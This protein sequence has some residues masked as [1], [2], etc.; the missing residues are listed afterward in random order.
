[1]CFSLVARYAGWHSATQQS[2]WD[3][4]TGEPANGQAREVKQEAAD[5]AE[6]KQE[7]PE[8]AEVKQEAAD[9]AE[10]KQEAPESE[11]EAAAEMALDA[12][13]VKEEPQAEAE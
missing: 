11:E 10:V 2:Q 4:P 1:M 5:S 13:E 6:V 7:A 9:S 3:E 12:S 8:P